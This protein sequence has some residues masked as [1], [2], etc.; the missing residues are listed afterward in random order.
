MDEPEPKQAALNA[1]GEEAEKLLSLPLE[2]NVREAIE[3]IASIARYRF[4]IRTS[5]E[6]NNSIS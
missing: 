2:G 1:I 3:R 6:Q 4:D 5:G